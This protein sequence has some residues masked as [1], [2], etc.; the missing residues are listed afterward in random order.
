MASRPG[1]NE[2]AECIRRLGSRTPHRVDAARHRLTMLGARAVGPLIE[3]LE[4]DAHR[5]RARAMPILALIRDPRGREP[6]AAMLLDKSPRLRRIAARALGHFPCDGSV[7]ALERAVRRERAPGIRSAAVESLVGLYAA[8]VDGAIRAPLR[9]LTDAEEPSA[10]RRSA[11]PLLRDLRA[12]QRA[13]LLERLERDPDPEIRARAARW[14]EREA[15][16]LRDARLED[17]LAALG[18]DDFARWQDTLHRLA[19]RGSAVVEPLLAEMRSR[20]HDPEFCT[21]AGLVF[22][23][24]GPRRAGG[25]ADALA[26]LEEPLPLQVLVDVIGSWGQKSFIYRLRDLIERI[27]RRSGAP[28]GA[29]GFDPLQRVRARAHLELARVGSRVASADLVEAL[30]DREHRLEPELIEALEAIGRRDDIPPLL[31]A[32]AREDR[33][34]RERIGRAVVAIM[35]RERIRRNSR[36]FLDLDRAEKRAL[37]AIL[38]P[39]PPPRLPTGPLRRVRSAR[40]D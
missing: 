2:I 12:S 19:A 28:G 34:A 1:A 33:P 13:G 26:T 39:A 18:D 40:R 6:I 32:H 23:A 31:A 27:R 15:A 14:E 4:G 35:R 37:A 20:S 38:P 30:R 3:A 36:M 24:L 29:D 25:L 7:A 16:A 5:V 17:E 10:V 22:K 21:R 9:I 11:L 8:G